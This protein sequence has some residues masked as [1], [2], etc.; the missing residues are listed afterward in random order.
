MVT[1]MTFS[2]QLQAAR[3][4]SG[5]SQ[6]QLAAQMNV[7]RPAV[8]HWEN[9]RTLPDAETLKRLSQVLSYNF[10]T[11]ADAG[12][13]AAAEGSEAAE[14]PASGKRRSML[15]CACSLIA[16]LALGC[17]IGIFAVPHA[18]PQNPSWPTLPSG[19]VRKVEPAQAFIGITAN[20]MPVMARYYSK[21]ATRAE[22]LYNIIYKEM[23]GLDFT[24]KE[25]THS[26]IKND[27]SVA[28]MFTYTAADVGWQ[29]DV[30]PAGAELSYGGGLPVQELKGLR[31]SISGTDAKGNE[32][33]FEGFIPFSQT[34]DE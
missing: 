32:L 2:E 31:V 24:V 28:G 29:S 5:M 22:W 11:I 8:S 30:I 10:E 4:Q 13:D 6:E 23:N 26:E 14:A 25:I 17:L 33:M 9:G 18:A 3:K 7:S 20:E 1:A 12:A 16:G 15:W 34:I 19:V 21:N 27:G